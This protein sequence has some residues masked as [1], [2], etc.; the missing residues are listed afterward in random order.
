MAKWV[1][2]TPKSE[3]PKAEQMKCSVC[4]TLVGKH[5]FDEP[6]QL[7]V[8]TSHINFEGR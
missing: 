4:V 6:G 3:K 7:E 5:D 1:E 2:R 8:V